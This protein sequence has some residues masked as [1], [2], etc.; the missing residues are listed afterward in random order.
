MLSANNLSSMR[1][2]LDDGTMASEYVYH[3]RVIL[4]RD[5]ALTVIKLTT[6]LDGKPETDEEND[7]RALEA[8]ELIFADPEDALSGC[9]SLEECSELITSAV[10]DV[11]GIDLT[12]E[13]A[14]DT[15]LWDPVQDAPL[16]RISLR[17]AYGIDWDKQRTKLPWSEFV[18]L[19]GALPNSTPLGAMMYYRNSDNRPKE[20][21]YNREQIEEFDHYH[22]LFDLSNNTTNPGSH[23]RSVEQANNAMNDFALSL[24][25]LQE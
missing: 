17:M 13:K 10:Y 21:K 4:I 15:P 24:F 18:Y 8:I 6:L 22:D 9:I 1:V 25:G 20:T 19:V 16:I 5:D 7:R 14:T 23:D 12:G 3:D 2:A 11:Y